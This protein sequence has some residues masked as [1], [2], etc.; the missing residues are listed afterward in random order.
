MNERLT[1]GNLAFVMLSNSIND[2]LASFS[3]LQPVI[4]QPI[5][6]KYPVSVSGLIRMVV[7]S[8]QLIAPAV[9]NFIGDKT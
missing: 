6:F 9:L 1:L 8:A 2:F 7:G 3:P 5:L 4:G